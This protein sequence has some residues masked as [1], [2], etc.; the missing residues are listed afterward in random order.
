MFKFLD[1]K[2]ATDTAA[3]SVVI[4]CSS[5]RG[6]CGAIHG[7]IAKPIRAKLRADPKAFQSVVIGDKA[8]GQI[9]RASRE[10]MLMSFNGVGKN[11]PTFDEAAV[12]AEKVLDAKKDE[13]AEI[14]I[15]YNKF[16]SV[17]AYELTVLPAP[18]E[19]SLSANGT[20]LFDAR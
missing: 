14:S 19:S 8:R 20:N 6:L 12:V 10:A 4:A 1:P 18:S 16:K 17:I 7:T 3:K 5:D 15:Y 11:L 9:S 2:A 13:P